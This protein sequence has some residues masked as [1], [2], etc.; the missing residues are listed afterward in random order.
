MLKEGGHFLLIDHYAPEDRVLDDFINKIDKL[1]D[2][3]HVRE[4]SLSEWQAM[5][6][7][8]SFIYSEV[9]KWD[10][11]IDFDCWIERAGASAEV[12]QKIVSMVQNATPLCRETFHYA[13]DEQR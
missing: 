10:L 2:P 13:V 1:R 3:S 6:A 4:S 7:E 5:F 12:E 9:L 8:N 11:P